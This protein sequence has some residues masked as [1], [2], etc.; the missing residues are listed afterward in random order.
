MSNFKLVSNFTTNL[1]K[2]IED[3]RLRIE[4]S[5]HII[6]YLLKQNDIE[7]AI[8]L[9]KSLD[10][11][12][13]RHKCL[14]FILLDS[15][16]DLSLKQRISLSNEIIRV[17][18]SISHQSYIYNDIYSEKFALT[19]MAQVY[20]MIHSPERVIEFIQDYQFIN[21]AEI[22]A[23]SMILIVKNLAV[24]KKNDS[25]IH[26]IKIDVITENINNLADDYKVKMRASVMAEVSCK[27]A[28]RRMIE[29]SEYILNCSKHNSSDPLAKT[30][31]VL[32]LIE[33]AYVYA[34]NGN[35]NTALEKIKPI[36]SKIRKA[37]ALVKLIDAIN[38]SSSYEDRYTESLQLYEMIKASRYKDMALE[39]IACKCIKIK[40]YAHAE[41]C[42]QLIKSRESQQYL[43]IKQLE[44]YCEINMY[45]NAWEIVEQLR[46]LD[47]KI[48]AIISLLSSIEKHKTDINKDRYINIVV[49]IQEFCES[50]PE[51]EG[52]IENKII[53][54]TYL[55][56]I[57][58]G[59]HENIT[60]NLV[61]RSE[62]LINHIA[63]NAN[64]AWMLLYLSWAHKIFKNDGK[65]EEFFS[66]AYQNFQDQ[67][68]PN[69]QKSGFIHE[70]GVLVSFLAERGYFDLS[71]QLLERAKIDIDQCSS[72]LKQ[73]FSWRE[74][75]ELRNIISCMKKEEN[76]QE[77][78]EKVIAK[79]MAISPTDDK[80]RFNIIS[81]L[82]Q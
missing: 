43:K 57:Y 24:N 73:V 60:N 15:K 77:N 22:K 47:G 79:I 63:N 27:F 76:F 20:G 21:E 49:K 51:Q 74:L 82:T 71:I 53:M 36:K 18:E 58:S 7:S 34:E 69:N 39:K 31:Q 44:S 19:T 30:Y 48:E 37:D 33:I 45:D 62:L 29:L 16:V 3:N 23:N 72:E 8:V 17:F 2:Q 41:N 67:C 35:L 64:K 10:I 54:Y 78:I 25:N 14:I 81:A 9:A 11:I 59:E 13:D 32:A 70:F 75:L 28:Q 1:S 61:I 4:S 68:D 38:N 5:I 56:I 80:H 12:E 42:I 40:D 52:F 6:R 66:L 26:N 65:S 55:S 46:D 50:V